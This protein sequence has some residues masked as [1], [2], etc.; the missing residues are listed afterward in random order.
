MAFFD[1][2]SKT[3]TKLGQDVTQKTQT[4][5]DGV[6]ISSQINDQKKSLAKLY[7]DLG[8]VAY[9]DADFCEK[10]QAQKFVSM[11][12]EGEARLKDLERQQSVNKGEVQCKSCHAFVPAGTAFCQN[13]GTRLEGFAQENATQQ[14]AP[15]MRCSNCGKEME[16]GAAFCT[17]CGT[18]VYK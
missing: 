5:T 16:A 14:Q 18:P 13:C 11:I 8:R 17:N 7:E 9:Q 2:L 1:D 6:K 12:R 15:V 10:E 3:V 4:F